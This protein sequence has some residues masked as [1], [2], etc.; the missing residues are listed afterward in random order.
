[1]DYQFLALTI[2]TAIGLSTAI[3]IA[4]TGEL[5][6]EKVGV[7][8]IA[9]EGVMLVGALTGFIMGQ[10]TGSWVLG[11]IAGGV[12][13]CAFAIV[14]GLITVVLR[15]DMIVVGVALILVA[16]GTTQT[17]GASY[18]SV[19]AIAKIPNAEIPILST[20]PFIGTALFQQTWVTYIAMG[21]PFVAAF[22]L[23]RTRHGLNMRAIGE[24]PNAA[25]TAGISVVGWRL[26]Y[27]AVGGLL[28]GVGGAYITL[29]IVD[30]WAGNVTA[31]QGWIAF[32]IVFFAGWQ[33]LWI[34][35]G[36]YFFGALSVLG[37]VGQ[38]MGW[39]VPSEAFTV[40]PYVGTVAVMMLRAWSQ[41]RKGAVSWPASLGLPFYRG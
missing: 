28:A 38:I 33:P 39:G 20:L 41:K 11:L 30:S 36:A 27:V 34:L 1:M 19:E 32:A 17:I 29:G 35:V 9:L 23:F 15:T 24:N 13:G 21:L 10:T 18:V 12:A 2:A 3:L 16:L 5:L 26:F 6:V 31:G 40:L 25:D 7:Y 22:I 37:D 4:A 14:F 8:N